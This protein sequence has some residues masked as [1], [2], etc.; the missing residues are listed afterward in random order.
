MPNN[1]I[2]INSLPHVDANDSEDEMI[3][4]VDQ[5]NKV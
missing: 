1:S 4:R 2:D 3:N 5:V